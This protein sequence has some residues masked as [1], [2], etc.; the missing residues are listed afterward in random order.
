MTQREKETDGYNVTQ[1]MLNVSKEPYCL[2]V[3]WNKNYKQ[4]I[5]QI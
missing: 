5:M 4:I 3:Y 2:N 1:L